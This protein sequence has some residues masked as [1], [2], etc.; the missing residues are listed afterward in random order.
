MKIKYFAWIK[1]IT[2][3][4]EEMIKDN[5]PKT[6]DALKILLCKSYPDLEKHINND[7]LRYA[8]N[9]EYTSINQKL[10]SKDEIAIFPP[11]SGG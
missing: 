7:I 11:V 9:M 10:T 1:D 8:V 3:K 2:N 5:H 4:D 6:I